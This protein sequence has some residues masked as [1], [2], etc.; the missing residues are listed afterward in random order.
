MSG[1]N[2]SRI[3]KRESVWPTV[4]L[5]DLLHTVLLS[6]IL[7]AYLEAKYISIC[8]Q[9]HK[10]HRS[11]NRVLLVFCS[12]RIMLKNGSFC[13][14]KGH[15]PEEEAVAA[16]IF[17]QFHLGLTRPEI[18]VAYCSYLLRARLAAAKKLMLFLQKYSK[19]NT[20]S[21]GRKRTRKSLGG[22]RSH[23]LCKWVRKRAAFSLLIAS[24]A[25]RR[26]ALHARL[27]KAPPTTNSNWLQDI[28]R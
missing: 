23:R 20:N 19:K 13:Q 25:A 4:A 3:R 2:S 21:Q 8:P 6:N 14:D 7:E 18:N 27:K 26:D 22:F 10:A 15:I 5:F 11:I 24:M 12:N 17:C 16:H 9:I 1:Q 28:L